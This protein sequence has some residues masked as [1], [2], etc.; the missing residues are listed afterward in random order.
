MNR[1]KFTAVLLVAM[2]ATPAHA[3]IKCRNGAQLVGGDYISTPYCQDKLLAEV[4]RE[5]GFKA[6]FA[7]I[8]NNP[9]TKRNICVYVGRDIR[10]Q[11]NCLTANP[12][13]RRGM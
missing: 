10:V 13:G 5:Y 6:S 3:A 8:R 4:A 12:V 11:E 2:I 9:N 1:T 7:E